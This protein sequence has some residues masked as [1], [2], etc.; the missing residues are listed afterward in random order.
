LNLS[1]LHQPL[2]REGLVLSRLGFEKVSKQAVEK[3]FAW[4]TD[5][6]PDLAAIFHQYE[7]RSYGY[8]PFKQHTGIRLISKVIS[9]QWCNLPL[10]RQRICWTDFGVPTSAPRTARVLEHDKL[11]RTRATVMRDESAGQH[12]HGE[13]Y[14]L[15]NVHPR[16]DPTLLF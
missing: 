2:S 4:V 8:R 13:S 15:R 11:G 9:T 12:E 10:S 3:I 6:S 7:C 5:D 1:Q 14:P 16:L